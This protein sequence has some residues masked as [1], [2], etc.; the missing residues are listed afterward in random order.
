[1]P[2]RIDR[3]LAPALTLA[4]ACLAP[5]AAVAQAAQFSTPTPMTWPNAQD[6]DR[7]LKAHPFPGA[8]RLGSQPVPLPPRVNPRSDTV[9]IEAIARSNLRL[10]GNGAAPGSASPPL[11]IFITLEM[12]RPSLRLLTD[13]A[14]RSGAVLVLRGLKAQ[15]MRQ[16]IAVVGELIGERQVAWVIDPEAFTRFGVRQAP[17]FVLTLNDETGVDA[18]G[19]CSSGCATPAGFVSVSGDVSLDYALEAI[20]RRRPEAALLA[21]PI[22]KRLRGSP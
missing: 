19:N 14:A 12:P 4:L 2:A 7:A 10:Q 15:S 1:M 18:Q 5:C 13:Q 11:R 9:D 3:L 16:T 20:L 22:L 21:E 17:T 8:D 6:I